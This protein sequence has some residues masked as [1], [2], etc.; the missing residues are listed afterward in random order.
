M[1][2]ENHSNTTDKLLTALSSLTKDYASDI[3][4]EEG[5]TREEIAVMRVGKVRELLFFKILLILCN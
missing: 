5:K 3:M 1:D 2:Y 4:E